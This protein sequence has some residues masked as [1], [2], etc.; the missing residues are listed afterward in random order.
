MR[1]A[2]AKM[3]RTSG[4]GTYRFWG[5]DLRVES[6]WFQRSPFKLDRVCQIVIRRGIVDVK[7]RD[8]LALLATSVKY[9]ET[10]IVTF[11]A[12]RDGAGDERYLGP[13]T[14]KIAVSI[15][16]FNPTENRSPM[17]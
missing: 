12:G 9:G 15:L 7:M 3:R 5:L 10:G 11:M 2:P 16:E 6:G 13:D 8:G 17:E 4:S 1:D 14:V